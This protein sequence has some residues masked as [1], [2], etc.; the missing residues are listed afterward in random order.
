MFSIN[1][2][3]CYEFRDNKDLKVLFITRNPIERLRSHHNFMYP[4]LARKKQADL[5]ILI[6]SALSQQPKFWKMH[7]LAE[8]LLLY[9]DDRDLWN[10]SLLKDLIALYYSPVPN[11]KSLDYHYGCMFLSY[12]IY[13]VP[14]LSYASVFPLSQIYVTSLEIFMK[15]TTKT[16]S[17]MPSHLSLTNAGW[18]SNRSSLEE[19][20][21]IYMFLNV[22]VPASAFLER[23]IRTIG[24][25]D[26]PK[27]IPSAQH[28]LNGT[29]HALLIRYY[30]P[31]QRLERRLILTRTLMSSEQSELAD[32]LGK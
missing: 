31:F 4:T 26:S 30:Q 15:K 21:S 23:N 27:R 5:N 19:L 7:Q 8:K 14:I 16:I 12:S 13:V 25:H 29:T 28:E 10:S 17:A 9:Q 2:S 11:S 24:Q 1:L 20:R 6:L 22:S 3:V 18:L 32:S